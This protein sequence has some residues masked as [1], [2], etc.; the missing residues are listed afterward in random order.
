MKRVLRPSLQAIVAL[1]SCYT[2]ATVRAQTAAPLKLTQTIALPG[3]EGRID[4]VAFDAAG[5]RL[6]VCA[7]GNNTVEVIDLRKAERIHSITGLGA[8]QGIVYIPELDRL[9]VANDKGGICKIYDA[10]SFQ[11]VGELNF[12]DDADNVRYDDATK[13]IYVGFGS[14]GIAVVNAPDGK[15]IGSIKLSA[16]PEAFELEKQGKRI[17]INVPNSRDVAVIDRDKG[18]VIAT[19]KTDLAFGNFPMALDETNHRLFLGCRMPSKLIVLNTDSGDVVTKIDISGDP[20]DVFYDSKRHRI[21]AT[22]GAGKID[23]IEQT[24]ADAYRAL[25]K[26]DTADGART[27]LFVPERDTVFAA[28]PHRGSQQAE[29]RAYRVE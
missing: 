5:E 17:F 12:K 14:G 27:G 2:F 20:D 16:H 8:P 4:H 29:I 9:F 26:I 10:K 28:V 19:W 13:K 11:T 23:I 15:Q 25:A 7:L 22:C 1:A 24:G 18:E 21:Y 6:F 3:V